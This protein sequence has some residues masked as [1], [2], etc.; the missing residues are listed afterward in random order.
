MM[1]LPHDVG[2][3][4]PAILYVSYPLGLRPTHTVTTGWFFSILIVVV[5]ISLLQL[6]HDGAIKNL[7]KDATM[8][9][10]SSKILEANSVVLPV[11]M[12]DN[13]LELHFSNY[14]GLEKP[15]VLLENYE[16]TVGWFPVRWNDARLPRVRLG[17]AERFSNLQWPC[18]TA[19]SNSVQ[20]DYVCIY[21]TIAK[22]NDES[23]KEL[24]D[25]LDKN[26]RPVY[27]S[28]N[29]YVAIYKK[30]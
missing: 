21:G 22:I 12:S 15:L 1:R 19:S 6:K 5:H 20:I 14:L 26:F 4:L 30:L 18:N 11:N 17:D 7:D 9:V 27:T 28:S 10:E 29:N 8:L 16:A 13:W 24:K 3:V 23:W 25:V 2:S